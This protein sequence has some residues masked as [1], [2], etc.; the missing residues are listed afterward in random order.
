M[1][2]QIIYALL[3]LFII[4]QALAKNWATLIVTR[5]IAGFLAATIMDVP[6]AM[7]SDLWSCVADTNLP[8]TLFVYFYMAGV[9][10]GPVL[11][12]AAGNLTWRWSV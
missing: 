3:P 11:G 1:R 9:T 12:A 5:A 7:L 10:V 8:V 2:I 4:P 6:S